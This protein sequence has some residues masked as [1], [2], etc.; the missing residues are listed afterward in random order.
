MSA[1]APEGSERE[2]VF[3]VSDPGLEGAGWVEKLTD[4]LAREK[5]ALG[6]FFRSRFKPS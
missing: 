3:L 1:F 6:L 2:K 5:M 4:V